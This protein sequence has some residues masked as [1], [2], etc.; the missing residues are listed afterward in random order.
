M[1]E[2]PGGFVA[3]SSLGLGC[4]IIAMN[5]YFLSSPKEL[6]KNNVS[7]I[8]KEIKKKINISLFTEIVN[9]FC[10]KYIVSIN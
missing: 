10:F 2:K 3:T 8:S 9:E 5:R 6:H 4:W 7:R 1:P